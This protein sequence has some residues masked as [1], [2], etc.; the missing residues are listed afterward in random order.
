MAISSASTTSSPTSF[1]SRP[2]R[3]LTRCFRKSRRAWSKSCSSRARTARRGGMRTRRVIAG[4]VGGALVY[5]AIQRGRQADLRGQLALVT[6]GT[7]GLGFLLARELGRVGCQV[8]ICGR[9]AEQ[10]AGAA[11]VLGQEGL[12]S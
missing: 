9:N 11:A 5:A 2:R 4:L 12:G 7:R 10:V 8:A 3:M 1:H 6:G